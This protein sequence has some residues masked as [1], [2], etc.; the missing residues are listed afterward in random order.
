M[1]TCTK[2]KTKTGSAVSDLGMPIDAL[3]IYLNLIALD[4]YGILW[5]TN[6]KELHIDHVLPLSSFDSTDRKQ[7]LI[8]TNWRNLDVLTAR[9]NLVK[10]ARIL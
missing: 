7:L 10:G 8:A 4:K 1:K 2:C 6:T 5:S 9:E 3:V